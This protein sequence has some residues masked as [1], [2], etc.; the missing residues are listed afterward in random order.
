MRLHDLR[1]AAATLIHAGGGDLHAIKETLG[2]AG[3]AITSDTYLHLLPQVDRG[4]AEAA[5]A[6]VPLQRDHGRRRPRKRRSPALPLT[7]R[8][9]P[10]PNQGSEAHGEREDAGSPAGQGA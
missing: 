2:H 6:V 3:I 4:I 1:H 8:S 5:A 9:P 10:A 7:H